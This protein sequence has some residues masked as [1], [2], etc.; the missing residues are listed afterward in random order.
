MVTMTPSGHRFVRWQCGFVLD[1]R[2]CA[3][4]FAKRRSNARVRSSIFDE[5]AGPRP[6]ELNDVVV[7]RPKVA[8]AQEI[9][10]LPD[11]VY[12]DPTAPN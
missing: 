11:W 7:A 2:K 6:F 3:N 9:R 10:V 12:G 1:L 8:Q 4:V 5:F